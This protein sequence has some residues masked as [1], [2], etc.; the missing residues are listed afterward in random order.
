M[1]SIRPF[2]FTGLPRMTREQIAVQQSL[3]IYLSYQPF[4]DDFAT[5]LG[6]MIESYLKTSCQISAPDLKAISRSDL[7]PVVP[8][9]ACLLVIVAAPSEHKILVDLDSSVAAFCID[10]LLGGSGDVGRIQRP[11]TEI[12]EGVLSFI[13]LKVLAHFQSGWSSGRE[14][15]L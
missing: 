11:L 1:P 13:L 14:L 7:G 5:S 10:R 9:V 2:Q 3:A 6:K 8:A 4:T 12:E 15:S